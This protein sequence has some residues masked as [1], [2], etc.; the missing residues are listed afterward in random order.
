MEE[1]DNYISKYYLE[2]NASEECSG[3]NKELQYYVSKY[4][5]EVMISYCS[6][7]G[8]QD[9]NLNFE[10]N[11]CEICGELITYKD[12]DKDNYIICSHENCDEKIHKKCSEDSI[13][14]KCR[15]WA[16]QEHE[17]EYV[18]CNRCGLLHNEN[19]IE[20][21]EHGPAYPIENVCLTC[22]NRNK[23]LI[24][25]IKRPFQKKHKQVLE[26]IDESSYYYVR[27]AK[28]NF[29]LSIMTTHMIKGDNP[30]KTLKKILKEKILEAN[31]TGYYNYLKSTKSVCFTD[32]SIR[33]LSRHAQKYSPYGIAFMK[34][35]IYE[36]DGGPALYI[37]ENL[38]KTR[39]DCG[40]I[41]NFVNKI[42][43]KNFDFHHE[44]EWRI[45]NDFKF[46]LKKY[47]FLLTNETS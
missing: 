35:L 28:E 20:E 19:C 2:E 16:C 45:P 23:D 8:I 10:K 12:E 27:E 15:I 26:E 5:D 18:I 14:D 3:C 21:I 25:E 33:G 7:C 6:C 36:S 17:K 46:D 41:N 31:I 1:L 22:L 40:N 37:R 29:D 30:Y 32:L 34:R 4:D 9:H 39:E 44:R 38:L 43:I 13:C 42:N 24:E 11:V 47:L